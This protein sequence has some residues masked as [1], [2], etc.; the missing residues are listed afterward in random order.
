VT[1]RTSEGGVSA[2]VSFRF[3]KVRI[4]FLGEFA[5]GATAVQEPGDSAEEF[6]H[7]GAPFRR[8]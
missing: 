5:F 1:E 4:H 2:A 8:I 6:G 7:S 3:G